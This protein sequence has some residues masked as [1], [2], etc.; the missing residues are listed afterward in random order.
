MHLI[1]RWTAVGVSVGGELA[2]H[3]KIAGLAIATRLLLKYLYVFSEKLP[4]L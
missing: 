1:D 3:H 2:V 4:L